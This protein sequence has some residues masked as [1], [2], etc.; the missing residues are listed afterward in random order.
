MH[1]GRVCVCAVFSALRT[2]CETT[3]QTSSNLARNYS[4]GPRG[5]GTA[6][7]ETTIGV[8]DTAGVESI[9]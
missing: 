2:M 8:C 5:D 7:P 4:A 3:R 9:E 1:A 6:L